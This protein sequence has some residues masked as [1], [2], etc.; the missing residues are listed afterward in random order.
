MTGAI[1]TEDARVVGNVNVDVTIHAF[2]KIVEAGPCH[3]ERLGR[4]DESAN[5]GGQNGH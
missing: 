2:N 1:V 5:Y 4:L 3:R